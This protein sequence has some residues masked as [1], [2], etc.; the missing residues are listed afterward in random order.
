M[1]IEIK[2]TYRYGFLPMLAWIELLGEVGHTA[3][4][5]VI[6]DGDGVSRLKFKFEDKFMQDDFNKL[7]KNLLKNINEQNDVK[8]FEI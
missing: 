1:K 6:A 4:F 2:G 5:K 7:R 8:L 3:N